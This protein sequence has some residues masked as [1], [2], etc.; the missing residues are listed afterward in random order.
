MVRIAKPLY[1]FYKELPARMKE[2]VRTCQIDNE[3]ELQRRFETKLPATL[4]GDEI[5]KI[6]LE[7]SIQDVDAEC[8]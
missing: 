1:D 8:D 4:E 6:E 2:I 3:R 7:R 5:D